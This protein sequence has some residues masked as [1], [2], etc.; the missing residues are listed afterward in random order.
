[1]AVIEGKTYVIC[2]CAGTGRVNS[3]DQK[4]ILHA[5]QFSPLYVPRFLIGNEDEKKFK[6]H[7]TKMFG[8]FH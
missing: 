7:L 3:V 6:R 5:Q 8:T 4:S 1:M 2:R